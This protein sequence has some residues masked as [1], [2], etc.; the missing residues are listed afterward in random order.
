MLLLKKLYCTRILIA[1]YRLSTLK[2]DKNL[3][4]YLMFC[5][6]SLYASLILGERPITI[7]I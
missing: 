6:F 5:M 4:Q 7:I 1:K 3:Y 2:T